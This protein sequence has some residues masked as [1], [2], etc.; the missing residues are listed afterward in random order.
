MLLSSVNYVYVFS[1]Y[2]ITAPPPRP[3]EWLVQPVIDLLCPQFQSAVVQ[4][5]QVVPFNGKS[6]LKRFL[7]RNLKMGLQTLGISRYFWLCLQLW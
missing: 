6:G 2:G 5:E 7:P 4:D 1:F 3:P